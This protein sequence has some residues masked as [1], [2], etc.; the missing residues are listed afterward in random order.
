MKKIVGLVLI[1]LCI[2]IPNSYANNDSDSVQA[3]EIDPVSFKISVISS[4]GL[5]QKIDISKL[6]EIIGVFSPEE[7]IYRI[8]LTRLLCHLQNFA[9]RLW[10][11]HF[12]ASNDDGTVLIDHTEQGYIAHKARTPIVYIDENI[13]LIYVLYKIETVNPLL[14][15]DDSSNL[16]SDST[17]SDTNSGEN[18]IEMT[19][20]P[21]NN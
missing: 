8:D 21:V 14:S 6:P 12:I 19:I 10:E 1:I 20:T 5:F 9:K 16:T 2:M 15:V 17:G 18:C 13:N 4:E 3:S 11:D 7:N